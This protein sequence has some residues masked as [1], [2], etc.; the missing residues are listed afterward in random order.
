MKLLLSKDMGEMD[1]EFY[2]TLYGGFDE[3]SDDDNFETSD[4]SSDIVDSDFNNSE[5]D[6]DGEQFEEDNEKKKK[7]INVKKNKIKNIE[8]KFLKVFKML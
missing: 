7:K 2:K 5:S 4:E 1:D 3:K 8:Y 6:G